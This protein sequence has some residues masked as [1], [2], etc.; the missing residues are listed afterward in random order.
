MLEVKG[1][2]NGIVLDHITAGNGLTVFNKLFQNTEFSVVL[3][4]N[5][6]SKNISKKDIIKIEGSTDVD[7]NVLG[8]IDSG[9]TVNIIKDGVVSEKHSVSIPETIE[10]VFE[11]ENPRCIT[12]SD[13][14]ANPTFKLVGK[15]GS[16]EYACDY[17]EEITKYRL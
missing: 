6:S 17:C 9:I 3:L 8:L 5:V 12:N 4:M 1:I 2:N 7:L 10:G 13:I 14:W 11:C 15:N 16:L